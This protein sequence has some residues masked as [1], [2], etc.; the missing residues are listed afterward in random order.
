[1]AIGAPGGAASSVIVASAVNPAPDMP[2]FSPGLPLGGLT[3]MVA[4]P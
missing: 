1:M 2:I 3:V 4:W